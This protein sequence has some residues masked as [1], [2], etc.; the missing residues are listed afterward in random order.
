MS[1]PRRIIA[2][3]VAGSG[4]VDGGRELERWLEARSRTVRRKE[5]EGAATLLDATKL[6]GRG[7]QWHLAVKGKR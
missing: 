6:G 1:P 4:E 3:V 7:R 5:E 2:I